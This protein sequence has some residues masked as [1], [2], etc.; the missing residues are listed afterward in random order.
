MADVSF[1]PATVNI[2][3]VRAGDRNLFTMTIKENGSAVNL[4]GMDVQAQVRAKA[5]D[6]NPSLEAEIVIVNEATGQIS[7][8]FPGDEVTA[9]LAGSPTWAGVWDLQLIA[10]NGVTTICQGNF[11]AVLDITR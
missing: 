7:I 10:P 6:V 4:N 2:A 11:A 5:T 1:N 3:G 8:Q 9:L